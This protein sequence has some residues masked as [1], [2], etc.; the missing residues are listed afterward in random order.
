MHRKHARAKIRMFSNEFYFPP[1]VLTRSGS[2]GA[3]FTFISAITA[4]LVEKIIL[5]D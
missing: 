1:L 5:F 3:K 4:P 2:K